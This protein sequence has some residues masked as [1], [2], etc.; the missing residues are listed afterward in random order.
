MPKLRLVQMLGSGYD[1]LVPALPTGVQLANSPGVNAGAVAEWVLAAILSVI[2]EFP[3]FL[4]DQRQRRWRQR[5]TQELAGQK[6]LVIGNGKIGREI[7]R[8]LRV[9][10][11]KSWW[12]QVKRAKA[13]TDPMMCPSFFG[14]SGRLRAMLDVTEP[15][16]LPRDHDLWNVTGL[17]IT[18]MW[19][20]LSHRFFLTYRRL[21]QQLIRLINNE[22]PENLVGRDSLGR[23]LD[24][25]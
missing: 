21:R 15:E 16:P 19:P 10:D 13:F 14:R 7:Q 23:S 18:L 20:Q 25:S 1:W 9:F 12:R 8:R 17:V 3:G 6:I 24:S 5:M 4:R 2:R 11:T 22:R